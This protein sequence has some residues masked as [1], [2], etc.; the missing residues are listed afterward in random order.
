MSN[1]LLQS[2]TLPLSVGYVGFHGD[3]S[4]FGPESGLTDRMRLGVVLP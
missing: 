3:W 4:P 2:R 1:P